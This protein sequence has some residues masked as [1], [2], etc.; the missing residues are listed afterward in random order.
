MFI[1]SL[2]YFFFFFRNRFLLFFLF[3]NVFNPLQQHR[4]I[5]IFAKKQ[6]VQHIDIK[7]TALRTIAGE[8]EA[9]SNLSQ[10]IT[11]D[12]VKVVET[13]YASKGRVIVTGIGKSA[14]IASKIV[15][16]LNS[17]GTPA[18]FM[19]AADAVHGDLG[20][21][22]AD[23]VVICLSNSGNTAEI[24]VLVPF[25]KLGSNPLIAFVGNTDSFLARHADFI[26]QTTVGEEAC[27]NN[28]AP[29]SSTTAQL[30]MGDALAIALL[31]HRGFTAKDFARYHPAG[32]LGKK[33]YLRVADI[34][35]RNEAPAVAAT[36]NIREVI[37]EI[38]SKRLGATAVL[39]TEKNLIGMITDGDLRRMMEEKEDV[40]HLTAQDIMS[41]HP[42]SVSTDTLVS[43]A[44]N[45]MRSNNITQ[46]LVVHNGRYEG[47]IHLHDILKEGIL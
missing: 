27:P 38:S 11:D 42:R 47:V 2:S 1:C 15:G 29:T 31:N 36:S 17:T 34:Y 35:T 43:E 22:R 28:L 9:I 40:D 21:I 37:L 8:A 10:Y 23:D 19:H 12:F 46:L 14:N 18:V 24:K 26:V 41:S 4:R 6:V 13:I 39:D 30:V 25:V 32:T 45:V 5:P 20:I 44:L 16:T 7:E 33:L 3:F